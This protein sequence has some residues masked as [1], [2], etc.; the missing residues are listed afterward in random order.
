MQEGKKPDTKDYTL[1]DSVYMKFSKRQNF[2]DREDIAGWQEPELENSDVKNTKKL[3][4]VMEIF[5]IVTVA[6]V[7]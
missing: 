1:C 7:T 2:S 3:F 6:L 4:G 5:Y